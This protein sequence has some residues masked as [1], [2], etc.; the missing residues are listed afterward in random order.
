MSLRIAFFGSDAFSVAS[1]ARLL[2]LHH[3]NPSLIS[4]I[5]VVTRRIKPTGRKLTT[6]VDLPA[7][8]FATRHGLNLW[9][10]DSAEEI[11][12]IAPRGPNHMAVAVSYGKL[13]PAE[14][15]SQMGHGGLNV[16][17]SLLPMYSGSAP[18]QHALMDD[19]S[20]TGVSVQTL[21]PTK[22]DKGAILAQTSPIPILEDDNYHSLQA[23]LSEVGA[24]LLAHVL[25]K[26]LYVPPLSPIKSPYAYSLAKKILPET[27]QIDWRASSRT[28]KRLS[29]A[30]GPLHTFKMV[31]IIKK[32][33]RVHQHYKVILDDIREHETTSILEKA[34]PGEFAFSGNRI[35]V[36]T[37]DG[38][39]SVGSLKF[40]YCA[41]ENPETFMARLG[42]RA[43]ETPRVF[44]SLPRP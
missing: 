36:K 44:E 34:L 10:A 13:I 42:K 14:Y 37:G 4:S 18:L 23:R 7:G 43:G 19:V 31:D 28:I 38:I 30:L 41:E 32:K 2:R 29:D 25:E 9:R 16:H 35:L 22:F 12:N 3:E 21:H 6:F 5:D 1:L 39:V 27:S 24:D 8:D 20:E 40:Q 33:K 17:P 11:L 15:L 26:K